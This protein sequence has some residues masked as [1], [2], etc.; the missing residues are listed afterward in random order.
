MQKIK[1]VLRITLPFFI[2]LFISKQI[3]AQAISAHFFGENAWMP[4]QIGN[5]VLNGKLDQH[6]GDIK[7][8]HVSII[9]FGGITPDKDMPTNAQYIAIIDSIRANGMEP[10]IQVPFNNNAYNATQAAAIVTFLNVTSGKNIKYWSIGNEPDLGYSYSTSSQIAA[11]IKPFASAMKAVDPSIIIIGPECAWYNQGIINGITTPGGPD[12]ITGKDANGNYYVDVISFHTYPFD[13]TQTRAQVVSKMSTPGGLADNLAS[14]NAR[15]AS[16]NSYHSRTG[17]AALKTAITE[18]NIDWKNSATDDVN[19]VGANSFLGGQFVAEMLGAAMK[20]NVDFVTMWS[21]IEGNSTALNIGYLDASTGIKKPLYYHYQLLAQN[22]KGNY[23]NGTSN[24][25][26]VKTFGCQNGQQTC[27]LVMNEDL[28]QYNYT[29]RLNTAAVSG[30]SPLKININAS[31]GT[32]FTDMIQG[33]STVLLVFNAQGAITGKYEYTLSNH[34]ANHLAP[35]YTPFTTG[36]T[37]LPE[38]KKAGGYFTMKLFPNP[39]NAKFTVELSRL[40]GPDEKFQ[41]ELFDIEGRQ[42]LSKEL[43]FFKGKEELDFSTLSASAGAY[44]VRVR[45]NENYQTHKI[46]LAK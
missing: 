33:Q 21:V 41:V 3:S 14:L 16:C 6:W 20:N 22:F 32:E 12:D 42:I 45:Q 35:A 5:T 24:L 38:N 9:R 39:T 28:G 40:P 37:A 15:I 10:I 7:N 23:V 31:L 2:S 1:N 4:A 11:Y 34:A 36:I 27:V 46:I 26:N 18:L 17:N 43:S 30:S 19:G 29:V 25:A 44:V 13:G 8:S